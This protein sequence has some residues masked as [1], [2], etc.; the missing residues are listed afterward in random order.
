MA[1]PEVDRDGVP[2]RF[3]QQA[4]RGGAGPA[5]AACDLPAHLMACCAPLAPCGP[6]RLFRV[7][8]AP[9]LWVFRPPDALLCPS[10][11]PALQCGRFHGLDAF[12]GTQ[13]SCREQL[14]NHNSRRRFRRSHAASSD[15]EEWDGDGDALAEGYV[16][17]ATTKRLR[18]KRER[19][20]AAA[21][22][23]AAQQDRG[24]GAAEPQAQPRRQQQHAAPQAAHDAQSPWAQSAQQPAQQQVQQNDWQQLA[25]LGQAGVLL[26]QAVQAAQA[27]QTQQAHLQQA[28]LAHAA[29]AAAARLP[30][31][32]GGSSTMQLSDALLSA[33]VIAPMAQRLAQLSARQLS[34][35]QLSAQQLSADLRK[36]LAAAAARGAQEGDTPSGE[37]LLLQLSGSLPLSHAAAQQGGPKQEPAEQEG[38]SQ[39][40]HKRQRQSGSGEGGR[41]EG[42]AHSGSG[43]GEGGVPQPQPGAPMSAFRAAAGHGQASPQK[44][45]SGEGGEGGGCAATVAALAQPGRVERSLSLP[46]GPAGTAQGIAAFQLQRA[47]AAPTVDESSPPPQQAP[48]QAQQAQQ[49]AQQQAD[50]AALLQASPALAAAVAAAAAAQQPQHVW[51]PPPAS[52]SLASAYST[53]GLGGSAML[54][55]HLSSGGTPTAGWQRQL[56]PAALGAALSGQPAAAQLAAELLRVLQ[57]SQQPS[58]PQQ[59]AAQQAPGSSVAAALQLLEQQRVAAEAAVS[60]QHLSR[61]LA[62]LQGPQQQSTLPA[63]RSLPPP[64]APSAPT[65]SLPAAFS[66]PSLPPAQSLLPSAQ[67]LPAS[68]LPYVG[69]QQQQAQPTAAAPGEQQQQRQLLASLAPMLTVLAQQA[70]QAAQQQQQQGASAFNPAH[71]NRS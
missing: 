54:S 9:C 40:A 2:S 30:T 25:L 65:P 1:A 69:S 47:P 46:T 53:L 22:A 35:Q 37:L 5:D 50:L 29:A 68:L 6:P 60:E 70:Q 51:A 56:Q 59:P 15:R 34:A 44:S 11:L 45:A 27:Q 12:D 63:V 20:A 3:C 55:Q 38:M 48:Q 4:R 33:G 58:A 61:I 67:S 16:P 17:R 14:A 19:E 62:V 41:P 18:N 43:A 32:S 8:P 39:W 21:A 36:G 7:C 13:R 31:E 64:G 24:P 49:Q 57:T 26:Q 52:S 23:V 10:P 66:V 71:Y 42:D 28:T